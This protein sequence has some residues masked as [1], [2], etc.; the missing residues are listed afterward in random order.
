M[1]FIRI[2]LSTNFNNAMDL[3]SSMLMNIIHWLGINLRFYYK[4]KLSFKKVD[5]I[6]YKRVLIL[7]TK[8]IGILLLDFVFKCSSYQVFKKMT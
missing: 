8:N 1:T 5:F 2:Y 6:N 7:E 4:E 3:I